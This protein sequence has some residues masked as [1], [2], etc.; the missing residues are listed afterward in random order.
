MLQGICAFSFAQQ[1]LTP[2][3]TFSHQKTVFVTK[4]D[5]KEIKG[6][7]DDVDRKKGLIEEVTILD[8]TGAKIKLKASDIKFMYLYPSGMDKLGKAMKTISDVQR[9]NDEK[10]NNDLINQGYV[11]IEQSEVQLKKQKMILLMQLLN[12]TFSKYVKIYYDPLAGE[13]TSYGVGGFTVAGGDAKSYFFK[14]GSDVAYKLE[15]KNYSDEFKTIWGDCDKIIKKYPE[16]K[17]TDLSKH[18]FEYSSE[19]K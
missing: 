17:W 4:T 10:L 2:T 1:L 8:T 14:K 18:T 12:P 7:L 3:N 11:Y 15:K 9:W 6:T 5:G 16:P 13:T 19:C